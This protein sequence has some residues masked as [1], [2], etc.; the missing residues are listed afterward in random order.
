MKNTL[1]YLA[2]LVALTRCSAVGPDYA[3]PKEAK[4]NQPFAQEEF[5]E[6]KGTAFQKGAVPEEWWHLYNDPA[7]DDLVRSALQANTD[8]RVAAANVKRAE[9]YRA[10]AEDKAMPQTKIEAGASNTKLSAEEQLLSGTPLPANNVYAVGG[11]LSYQVDLF[12]QVQRAIEASSADEAASHASYDRVKIG[13][14]AETTRAY[15]DVCATGKQIDLVVHLN[16]LQHEFGALNDRLVQSGRGT[17]TDVK[18]LSEQQARTHAALPLLQAQQK[19]AFYRLAAFVG[20]PSSELP[21]EVEGCHV[22]P[23]IEHALPTGDGSA[24]LQRRPDIRQAEEEFKAATARIGVATAELYP[25]ITLGMSGGSVGLANN[26]FSM[27][28]FKYSM[29]PLIS[30]NF[31]NRGS[32]EA[33]I[34]GAEAEMDAAYARFDGS[35]LKALKDV[36]TAL[37]FYAHDLDHNAD[38]L[39]AQEKAAQIEHDAARLYNGGR[40]N[41]IEMLEARRTQLHAEQDLAASEAK[42]LSD[43]VQLFQALG[44]GWQ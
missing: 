41:M 23:K 5:N 19:A 28:T 18:R 24:L 43:Q 13:I 4:I 12:G 29:G 3:V 7:L 25:H 37:S 34:Q 31:P 44:G 26:L 8:L 38:L 15:L 35:V 14:I 22:A 10:L 17:T 2:L 1:Y 32:A 40:S 6:G 36:E 30:W 39:R 21:Q 27:D 9:A 16:E 42:L 33:R 20:K 11:A